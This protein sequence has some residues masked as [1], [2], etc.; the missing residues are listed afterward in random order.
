[1]HQAPFKQNMKHDQL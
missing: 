1:M